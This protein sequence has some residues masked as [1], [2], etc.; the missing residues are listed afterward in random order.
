MR[1]GDRMTTLDEFSAGQDEARGLFEALRSAVDSV[2][3]AEMR[4]T[5]SQIAFRRRT[6]FAWAWLPATYLHDKVAPLV[7]TLSLPARDKS[8]RW[9]EIVKPSPGKYTHHLELNTAR[10]IDDEVRE[11]LRAA[12]SAAA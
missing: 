5:K 3:S 9:K 2:G 1:R 8:S 10:D 6:T 4:V 7:L 11:W 12:W